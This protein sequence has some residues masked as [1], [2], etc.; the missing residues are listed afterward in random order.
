MGTAT[1]AIENMDGTEVDGFNIGL[2][3][4][5]DKPR[6]G[7]GRGG[8]FGGGRGG[9]FGGGHGGGS[10][11][12]RG[13][14][15]SFGRGRG[16]GRGEYSCH[17][18]LWYVEQCMLHGFPKQVGVVLGVAKDQALPG[19]DPYKIFKVQR[20]HST[21][22]NGPLIMNQVW[23]STHV[24]SLNDWLKM[25]YFLLCSSLRCLPPLQF[26]TCPVCTV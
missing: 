18:Y 15:G 11:G 6:E 21:I 14:G 23:I 5:E 8:S 9:S 16:G 22:E 4:A 25:A 24:K 17:S 3:Y 20:L 2:R 13:G 26:C 10:F 7:G 1:K 12:G 19:Q